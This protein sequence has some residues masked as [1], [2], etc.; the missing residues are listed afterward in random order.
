M[1]N[2]QESLDVASPGQLWFPS[3]DS[4]SSDS[5][6]VFRKVSYRLRMVVPNLSIG[7]LLS[8]TPAAVLPA[9]LFRQEVE[10]RFIF[11]FASITVDCFWETQ[12]T[13]SRKVSWRVFSKR[14]SGPASSRIPDRP[15][16]NFDRSRMALRQEC[17]GNHYLS[18]V[19]KTNWWAVWETQESKHC[20]Q[21]TRKKASWHGYVPR[22]AGG[23]ITMRLTQ[24]DSVTVMQTMRWNPSMP[25]RTILNTVWPGPYAWDFSDSLCW[26]KSD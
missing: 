3:L 11:F 9:L 14:Q 13:K 23:R 24:N 20:R 4:A 19:K 16:V 5:C 1:Q 25:N 8:S 17:F 15:N 2:R 12:S 10:R 21:S 7:A 6:M 26:P 22:H 18:G